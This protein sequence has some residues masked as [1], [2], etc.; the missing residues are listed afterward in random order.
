M[1]GL[2]GHLATLLPEGREDV[3]WATMAAILAIAR[4]CEPWSEL[5][6]P[7]CTSRK[8]GIAARPSKICWA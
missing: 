7:N 4:F 6:V 8:R 1:L 2:D 5:H 3:P